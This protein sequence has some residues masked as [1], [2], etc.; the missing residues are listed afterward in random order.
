MTWNEDI[1]ATLASLWVPLRVLVWGPGLTSRAQWIEKR[2]LVV[3]ALKQATPADEVR[4]SEEIIQATGD[5]GLDPGYVELVHAQHADVIIALALA[6]PDRQGGVYREL[7]ILAPHEDLRSKVTVFLPNERKWAN[8]FAAG[9]LARYEMS[10][11][12]HLDWE[13]FNACERTRELS[14]A[15]VEEVR[16]QR[17]YRKLDAHPLG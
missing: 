15:R 4:T 14:I 3:E 10:Q 13:E 12:I 17:M 1:A 6:S 5:A 2:Q 11:K 16:R 8:A 9:A 7:E